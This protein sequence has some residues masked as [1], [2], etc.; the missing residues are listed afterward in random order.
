M[1]LDL[2]FF[3]GGRASAGC[4]DQLDRRDTQRRRARRCLVVGSSCSSRRSRVRARGCS[5]RVPRRRSRRQLVR[6]RPRLRHRVGICDLLAAL[7][8]RRRRAACAVLAA[9]ICPL[10][11]RCR[12]RARSSSDGVPLTSRASGAG[13]RASRA[14]PRRRARARGA[15]RRASRAV[16][17]AAVVAGRARVASSRAVVARSRR[18]LDRAAPPSGCTPRDALRDLAS[19]VARRVPRDGLVFTCLT[20]RGS[21]RRRGLEQLPRRSPGASCTSRAGRRPARSRTRTSG[22]GG[23]PQQPR[24]S[25][26]AAGPLTLDGPAVVVLVLVVCAGDAARRR[27]PRACT[28]TTTSR[29]TRSRR[30]RASARPSPRSR[31]ARATRPRASSATRPRL[32]RVVEAPRDPLGERDGSPTGTSQPVSPSTTVSRIPPTGV[33]TTGT[34]AA[35]ASITARQSPSKRDGKANTSNEASRSGTSSRSPRNSKRSPSG[36]ASASSSSRSSPVAGDDEAHVGMPLEHERRGRDQVALALLLGEPRDVA[37]DPSVEDARPLA[38]RSR[39]MPSG[40]TCDRERPSSAAR[41][42]SDV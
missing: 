1:L 2:K 37:D 30:A 17:L 39:S 8:S 40:T 38:K 18:G 12:G 42:V 41:S 31:T 34:P 5:L 6:R 26:V 14:V 23:S 3:P 33:A 10:A 32:V 4:G 7:I 20:G 13:A 24:S 25:R 16:A 19:S 28:R 29:S 11:R 21:Q 15:L 35:C 9:R 36:A 27:V 22:R